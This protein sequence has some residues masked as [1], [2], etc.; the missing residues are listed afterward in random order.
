VAAEDMAVAAAV[1]ITDRAA[2][3]VAEAAVVEGAAE[4]TTTAGQAALT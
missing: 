1:L 2:V 3:A 4:A